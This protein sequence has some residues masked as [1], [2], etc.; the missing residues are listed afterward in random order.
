[1]AARPS[2]SYAASVAFIIFAVIAAICLIPV[3]R[4]DDDKNYGP[5]IGIDLGTTYSCVG[6]HRGGRVEIIANDQGNRITPSWVQFGDDERLIGDA[7]KVVFHTS[8]SQT[9]FDAKPLIGCKYDEPEVKRDMKHWPFK[10]VNKGGKPMIQV[11]N[12]NELKDF[13]PEEISAMVLTK[14]KETAEA[15]L[16][17]KVTHAVVTVPAYFNDAQRQATKDAGT[18][19]GLT[20]LRIVNEPTAAAI[21][22]GLDKKGGETQIIVYDLGGGTFDV[23]L[24]SI[25]GGVFKVL[26]TAGDTHLGG[27][28]FDNRVI[29]HFIRE[30]KK[31]TGTDVT[32]NQRALSKLKKEVEKA[33]RTLSSQMST[34][35]EIE[36]FE[37]GNDFSETLT[38]SKFEELNIDLFRKTMKPVE[39]VLKDAGVKKEDISDIVLVGG[40]TR[41]PKVQ[42]LIKEYFGKEPSK[43][44]N[45]DE[46][47]AYG[48][49]IQGG[50]LSGEDGV[51]D[52]VLIDV[53]P[54]TLGIE[55]T[56]GV[57][58]KL[59]PRNTVVPTKKSQI[60]STAADNQPTVLIQV[61][62]GERSL[63]K[64]N[65]LLGKFELSGIPPAQRGVP[66][67]EVSFEIDANGILKVGASDKG[68]GKSESITITNEKGRLSKEEIDRMVREAE[69]YAAE[70]E[71]QRKRIEALNGLQNFIW[72]LK[73]QLGD[74]EGLGGKVSDE[75]KKTILATVK[76][77]TE[78]LEENGQ[79]ATSEELEEKLQ[80]VQAVVNPIT[81]KLYGSGSGSEGSSS[82]DEL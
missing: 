68:T 14:M 29:E 35:L 74:Q 78:W 59:I 82:H 38:R 51:D 11:K 63:T 79:S 13:T 34:K 42:Q 70:D 25:D 81:G 37:N 31:K 8:P 2:R 40:S 36:S 44:I 26:A 49:A 46:A 27:E 48:A 39:Q 33:K 77:T 6:V 1:M 54:L 7:A 18:I 19:A 76:E 56:G 75:D 55:T 12:K 45:P 17:K 57:F 9:V 32:K 4:A 15:Y 52:V 61:F 41:I 20:V 21:A 66:Q 22:Y 72:G 71:A 5:V 50:I 73:S 23:S 62:E 47:V 53:C 60:F 28:D 43:G 64:D 24:L 58:T 65:N 69:E 3:A 67:I 16:G 10:I 80:E 30:Y